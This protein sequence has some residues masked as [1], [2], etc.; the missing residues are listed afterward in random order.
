MGF[1]WPGNAS[2]QSTPGELSTEV[3]VKFLDHNVGWLSKVPV[4]SGKHDVVP[5]E[6][7]SVRLS[8]ERKH[9]PTENTDSFG[10]VLGSNGPQSTRIVT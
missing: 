4:V 7:I 8:M 2:N 6:A 10:S 1:K 5:V 9:S 3:Y